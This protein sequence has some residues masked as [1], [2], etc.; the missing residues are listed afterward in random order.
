MVRTA[1][2]GTAISSGGA[3]QP[4][5]SQ[6]SAQPT[7]S[8]NNPRTAQTGNDS[9]TEA[10]TD[11][12]GSAP[13]P[14]PA[15]STASS[16]ATPDVSIGATGGDGD[17]PN[18]SSHAL[19]ATTDTTGVGTDG[20][21]SDHPPSH[22]PVKQDTSPAPPADTTQAPQTSR[23]QATTIALAGE[24][25]TDHDAANVELTTMVAL[26]TTRT[27]LPLHVDPAAAPSPISDPTHAVTLAASPAPVTLKTIVTDWLTWIGLGALAPGVPVPDV[28]APPV[29]ESLWLAA[30]NFQRTY[31]SGVVLVGKNPTLSG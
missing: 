28:P 30:R 17:G 6:Y 11:G 9:I 7:R 24:P 23:G 22:G 8:G 20:G 26:D 31:G 29:I 5:Q 19:T 14:P 16:N 21:G 1:D 18:K 25:A 12:P 2:Q 27:A 13:T 4:G 10:S 3:E 15:D